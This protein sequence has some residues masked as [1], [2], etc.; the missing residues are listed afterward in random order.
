MAPR[1]R[2]QVGSFV[3]EPGGMRRDL[4]RLRREEYDL[5][6]I[7]GG[8]VGCGI[9]R[10]AALRGMRTALVEKDDFA[11]GT[12]SRSS[13]LV[14]GGIRYLEQ[15][16]IGLVREACL[17]RR[18]LMG[19]APHLVRPLPF[20]MP[21]RRGSPHGRLAVKVGMVLYD[22]LA[23]WR[24]VARH[25]MLSPEAA[26]A[27]EPALRRDGLRGAAI[28]F[29]AQMDD[30]R[31]CLENAIAASEAGAALANHLE[32]VALERAGGRIAGAA[33]RDAIGGETLVVRAR[34]VV[35]A[36]GPWADRLRRLER[37]DAPR[38]LRPSRGTHVLVDRPAP[39]HALLLRAQKD[40][41]VLF[42]LPWEGRTLV[43]TTDVDDAGDPDAVAPTDAEVDSLLADASAALVGEPLERRDVL[44]SF[45]GL[46]PLVASA[47]STT[48][49]TSRRD[50]VE[51]GPGGMLTVVGGK[52]TT[53]RRMAERVVDGFAR[54]CRTAAL[55]L[56]GGARFDV[57]VAERELRER[58]GF[59][60]ESASRIVRRY[61]SRW[62]T[63]AQAA[64]ADASL[65]APLC[66]HSPA[67]GAEVVHAVR[68]EMATTTADALVRRLCL[69]LAPCAGRD[70]EPRVAAL[71]ARALGGSPVA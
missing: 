14:H 43:G 19:I 62:S 16:E 12:S 26:L 54:G 24:N 63:V 20:L 6:V 31:L 59:S 15:G 37:D 9:A 56:P 45:A 10:D 41:R 17:E 21:I 1:S 57:E 50:H 65:V 3:N 18:T 8:I 2:P 44:A 11:A 40:G 23:S 60:S 53:Y 33:C 4:E 71:V 30:A 25:R 47:A 39:P 38:L 13:K 51:V 28:F 52:Y 32:V 58:A 42:L 67:T 64:R 22:L 68:E 55:A 35:N 70:A 46:R 69:H 34:R 36:T 27:A 66:P 61:G 48:L 7:G 5:L 49:G 29:D